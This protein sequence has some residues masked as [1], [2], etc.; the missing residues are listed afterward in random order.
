MFIG[1]DYYYYYYDNYYRMHINEQ[2]PIRRVAFT[3]IEYLLL[4]V[5]VKMNAQS[6]E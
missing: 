3:N 6:N 5:V 1:N 2:M 4:I